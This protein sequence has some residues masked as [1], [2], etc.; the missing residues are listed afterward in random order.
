MATRYGQQ[1]PAGAVILA[2]AATAAVAL[3]PGCVVTATVAGL[4]QV[5][6]RTEEV[7]HD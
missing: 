5:T 7:P 1:L 6:L 4:G 2:G 3:S